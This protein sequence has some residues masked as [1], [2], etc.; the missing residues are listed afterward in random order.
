MNAELPVWFRKGMVVLCVL[1]CIVMLASHLSYPSMILA[2]GRYLE[3]LWMVSDSIWRVHSGQY[4]NIDFITPIGPIFYGMYALVLKLEPPS[5]LVAV[6]ANLLMG[7]ICAAL[8][9]G[10]SIRTMRIEL[11]ALLSLFTF[12]TAASGRD[13][14]SAFVEEA[15]SYL[16]PYNRWSWA[17]A[18]PAM[19][20]LLLPSK[21]RT[22]ISYVLTG[23]CG[24]ALFFLKMTYFAAFVG[25]LIVSSALDVI[26]PASRPNALRKALTIGLS[27]VGAILVG[28]LLFGAT[29]AYLA[30]IRMAAAANSTLRLNRLVEFSLEAATFFGFAMLIYFMLQGLRRPADWVDLARIGLMVGA[31]AGILIQNHDSADAP[32]YYAALV[33][34]Y[35]LGARAAEAAPA[36]SSDHAP[37]FAFLVLALLL[38]TPVG[39]DVG[40]AALLRVR[41]LGEE[42]WSP[43][44][45]FAGTPLEPFRSTNFLAPDGS[46]D[47]EDIAKSDCSAELCRV[48][49]TTADGVELLKEIGPSHGSILPLVFSNPFSSLMRTPP[50]RGSLIWWHHGRSFSE[51]HAP[52][53]DT[54]FRD[55][56]TVL[57]PKKDANGEALIKIYAETLS[58]DYRWVGESEHWIALRRRKA[59]EAAQISE[60]QRA[61]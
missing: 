45:A 24:A 58:Q 9:I 53:A 18:I 32:L 4:P 19:I 51:E 8:T 49:F 40:K 30:D 11:V 6:H 41:A 27:M 60:K 47:Q 54:V 31:G 57:V 14:G 13:F 37:I 38:I 21:S 55:V 48:L 35:A 20:G 28:A 46:F 52:P 23:A 44:A 56:E 7:L 5:L 10:V 17:L 3:D 33:L 50:P 34:A 25:A 29:S 36:P 42:P 15:T 12:L 59:P 22:G 16:A 26:S 2:T 1:L 43:V 39:S 61:E